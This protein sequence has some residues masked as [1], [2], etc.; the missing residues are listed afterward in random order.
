M[1]ASSGCALCGGDR[2]ED[3]VVGYDRLVPRREDFVYRRCRD[4]SL[5]A[6][7]PLPRDAEIAGLYPDEYAPHAAHERASVRPPGFFQRF[8]ARHRYAADAPQSASATGRLARAV[9]RPMLRDVLD[10]RGSNRLL[11]VGCGSGELLARYRALGWTVQGVEPSARAVAA[12]RARQLPVEEGDLLDVSLPEQHFDVI[13]MHHVI[14]HVPRPVDV[15]CRARELLAPGGIVLVV[16]PNVAG[17][18]FRLYGSCWY[19]LDAPRHLHLFDAGTLRRLAGRAGLVVARLSSRPSARVLAA[20]R[21][22]A[23]TQGPLLPPGHA[24]RAAVL[25]RSRQEA[26]SRS[27]RRAVRPAARAFAWLGLGETL[28]AQ[29]MAPREGR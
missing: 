8:A 7:Q 24:P 5:V 29:L 22:Y 18:G 2:F 10:P 28:H 11:D 25:A 15:L 27:F 13:L 21:H 19:A 4:C 16:T 26:P 17:M 14:E 3:A 12:C 6:L 20:S 9:A 1:T 23:R